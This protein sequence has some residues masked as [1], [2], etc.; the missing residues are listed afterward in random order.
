MDPPTFSN[1]IETIDGYVHKF[2]YNDE[3]TSKIYRFFHHD[4]LFQPKGVSYLHSGYYEEEAAL[5]YI[6]TVPNY[7][8][9][10]TSNE[11]REVKMRKYFFFDKKFSYFY[12]KAGAVVELDSIASTVND[13]I[14]EFYRAK[15]TVTDDSSGS[16]RLY[17]IANSNL[18][19]FPKTPKPGNGF[20]SFGLLIN[21]YSLA[22]DYRTVLNRF[23]QHNFY[24]KIASWNISKDDLEKFDKITTQICLRIG[25]IYNEILPLLSDDW[26]EIDTAT[27]EGDLNTT[28]NYMTKNI[29]N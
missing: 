7:S 21:D 14:Y 27:T 24:T 18:I 8:F 6:G 20:I 4:W 25:Q 19:D 5:N 15:F 3:G 29:N 12:A 17:N 26:V 2:T 16:A 11:S 13:K 23:Y 1:V 22:S 9:W 10:N 28:S